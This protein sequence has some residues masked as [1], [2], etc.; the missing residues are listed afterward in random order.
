L[1]GDDNFLE[2]S[3]STK[4]IKSIINGVIRALKVAVFTS[5]K[6]TILSNLKNKKK[7]P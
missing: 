2:I 4:K 6:K 7:G 5:F 3:I 1:N